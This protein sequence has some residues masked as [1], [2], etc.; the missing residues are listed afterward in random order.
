MMR[1]SPRFSRRRAACQGAEQRFAGHGPEP[2]F[3]DIVEQLFGKYD[4]RHSLRVISQVAR[5]CRAELSP[6]TGRAESLEPI[7]QLAEKRLD[8]LPP[9]A[10]PHR[11]GAGVRAA[12]ARRTVRRLRH[13]QQQP[14]PTR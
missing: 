14:R 7:G 2:S 8:A 4:G 10:H 3:A 11:I 1:T 12:R 9:T 6:A 5:E 13:E